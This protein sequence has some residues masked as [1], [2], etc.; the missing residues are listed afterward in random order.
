MGWWILPVLALAAFRPTHAKETTCDGVCGRRPL[1][2]SSNL[3]VVGGSNVLPGTWPWMVSFQITTYKGYFSTCGGFL[4]S[5]RFVLSAAHCFENPK[6]IPGITMSIG[7]VRISDP[8]P[9]AQRRSIKRLLNHEFYEHVFNETYRKVH[10]D[11]SLVEL[12]E[13]V[14]CTD[15]IQPACL[16]DESVVVSLLSH[17]YVSGFGIMDAKTKE[18]PDIM[19]EGPV[20]L[21]PKATC[22]SP[23]WWYDYILEENICAAQTER[24]I[25]TCQGDSGGPLMCREQRSERYWVVGIYSWG[26]PFCGEAKKPGVFASTQFYLDWIRKNTKED[27][28]LAKHPP[29]M[30]LATP[31]DYSPEPS[32]SLAHHQTMATP[33]DHPPEPSN[34]L[35]HHQTLATPQDYSPEPSNSLAH[36]QTMATPQDHPPEPSNSLAHHQTLATPQDHPPEPSNSPAHHQSLATPQ[37]HFPEPSNSLAH[38]QTLETPQDHPPEPSSSLVHNQTLGTSHDHPP[39]CSHVLVHPHTQLPFHTVAQRKTCQEL[40]MVHASRNE[41]HG[42]GRLDS[43]PA[44]YLGP[45][46]SSM[47]HAARKVAPEDKGP[48]LA[49]AD[50]QAMGHD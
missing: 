24:S 43:P 23:E 32:N 31:Q 18:L 20:D 45:N 13:P 22:S 28:S 2:G 3:R 4:I 34:S 9:D 21:I 46:C 44:P 26:P 50:L 8:G 33:Q 47:V 36:H 37:D 38:H 29:L 42:T 49:W 27:F 12:N 15:Y 41:A 16:P 10:N 17:C 5:P 40:C 11:I 6:E 30:T 35:A 48:S 14:N 19:Q 1:A 39:D 25:A 7:A